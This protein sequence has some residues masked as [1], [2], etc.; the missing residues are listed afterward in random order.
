MRLQKR[1][2]WRRG[3]VVDR[4]LAAVRGDAVLLFMMPAQVGGGGVCFVG[5]EG[6]KR[7]LAQITRK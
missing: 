3:S 4:D 1:G 7:Q 6:N 5:D 2:G